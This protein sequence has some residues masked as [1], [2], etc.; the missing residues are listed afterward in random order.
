MAQHRNIANHLPLL[1]VI[2]VNFHFTWCIVSLRCC[3]PFIVASSFISCSRSCSPQ[4]PFAPS[5]TIAIQLL[6][7]APILLR[8]VT[9]HCRMKKRIVGEGSLS[10][11][12]TWTEDKWKVRKFISSNYTSGTYSAHL[13]RIVTRRFCPS[14]LR[15]NKISIISWNE[16]NGYCGFRY[17]SAQ[18]RPSP[19]TAGDG[20]NVLTI[21]TDL[22]VWEGGCWWLFVLDKRQCCRR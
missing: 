9:Q 11:N 3:H 17:R 18:Q 14:P 2:T 20:W 5:V 8:I 6:T 22:L 7:G 4:I 13:P 15:V 10:A 12:T 1:R 19:P 21:F 16:K